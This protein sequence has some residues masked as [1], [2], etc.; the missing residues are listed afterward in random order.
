MMDTTSLHRNHWLDA[1]RGVAIG[2][3]LVWHL[4]TPELQKHVPIL[5]RLASLTWSGVDLFFVLSGFLIG[6]I[7]LKNRGAD[8]YFTTFYVR[9]VIRIIPL[10]VVTLVIFFASYP[11]LFSWQYLAFGQ[12]I[13]WA[14]QNSLGPGSIAMTWSL[15]VEEQFYLCLPLMVALIPPKMFPKVIVG[16]A[17]TAPIFRTGCHLLGNPHAA[18]LLLPARMDSLLIG[19]FIAWA[20]ARRV[21]PDLQRIALFAVWPLGLA[22]VGLALTQLD[23]TAMIMG[24][25]GYSLIALFYGCL[26]VIILSGRRALPMALAPL[27]WLGLGAYSLYLFHS[28][29][30]TTA[31][32]LLGPTVYAAILSLSGCIAVGVLCW[33]VIEK[34]TIRWA[35]MHFRYREASRR[36]DVRQTGYKASDVGE[37]L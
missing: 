8:G 27:A 15:A 29:I 12:N 2:Q 18:Y 25:I 7:L 26:L 32:G 24:T 33:L 17:I 35:H 37:A 5:G 6:G 10:Y 11:D 23:P 21:M 1:L 22:F 19:V 16:L 3:V 14:S 4:V 9:R 36:K 31:F 34:P 30:N 28:M 13:A 20:A